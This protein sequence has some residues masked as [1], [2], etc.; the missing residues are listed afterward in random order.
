[1]I[2][3]NEIGLTESSLTAQYSDK[4]IDRQK[5][6]NGKLNIERYPCH[7]Q[8]V[9]RVIRLVT[10]ASSSVGGEN[11]RWFYWS[12]TCFQNKISKA[13]KKIEVF[14]WKMILNEDIVNK[15]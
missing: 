11:R 12:K 14:T 9:E 10:K 5:K 13:W 3:W 2:D 8:A 4:F 6:E 7:T 15:S 1:M